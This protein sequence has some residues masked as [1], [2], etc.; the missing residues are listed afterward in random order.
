MLSSFPTAWGFALYGRQQ[1]PP[2]SVRK[3][4][5]AHFTDEEP[6][7]EQRS[8]A[9]CPWFQSKLL[10]NIKSRPSLIYQSSYL[11][12]AVHSFK[13]GLPQGMYRLICTLHTIAMML[14]VEGGRGMG[15]SHGGQPKEGAA[16]AM[17]SSLGLLRV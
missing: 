11:S 15:R 3:V 16:D 5:G 6:E 7:A 8:N 12:P 2:R 17:A 10:L 1:S 9:T 4:P 14:W 13:A